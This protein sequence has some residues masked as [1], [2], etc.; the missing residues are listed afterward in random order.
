MSTAKKFAGQT[1]IYGLS[2]IISRSLYFVLTPI[3]VSILSAR[4]YGIFTKMYSYASLLS[5]ILAFG[6]E[7]TFFRYLNKRE[8]EKDK[9]Y[10]NSFLA[11]AALSLVFLLLTAFLV[12]QIA[13]WLKGDKAGTLADYVFYVKC[14]IYILVADAICVIPFAKVRANGRPLR[15]GMIK[16]LNVLFVVG[17]NLFFLFIVPYFI[18]NQLPGAQWMVGWYRFHW[19]GYVFLSNLLASIFT[20]ILLLPEIISLKLKF[21][22]VM[23]S[24]MLLYSWPMLVAN[25]SFIINENLDKILLDKIL[26]PSVSELQVGIYGA[27]AKIA[28]FLSIFVQA[29]RLG[30]EPF[31]FSHAKN[32]NS[33]D[34]YARIMDY[35]VIAVSLIFVALV[36]NI[37]ILKYFVK[38]KDLVQ[39]DLYWS[40][41][42]AVPLLLFGYLSLGIYMNLSVW[43]KLSD[44]TRYGLYISGIGAVLTIVLNVVFI[45]KYGYMASAWV[46]LIA[47]ASMMILSYIWGQKNYPIPYNLKK[48]LAYI[49]SSIVI[50]FLSFSVFHRNLLIGNALLM[51]FA[52]AAFM[53]ERKQIMAILKK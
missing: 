32:K 53:A 28:I 25:I 2:T 31:F 33:G 29:F 12:P 42:K 46:S 19:V 4:V 1:A 23:F 9:V 27:C 13:Y 3:L 40:G 21:D 39:R 11:V 45:P 48:N 8:D 52:G 18:K 5:A 7:T 44:Q 24:E 26:P 30:A 6:M 38:A 49:I 16:F 17:L 15:Y 51:L 36:A 10:S 47:Y 22:W 35:F 14:F 50:V 43:Y 20:V 34:T 37:E 41:L